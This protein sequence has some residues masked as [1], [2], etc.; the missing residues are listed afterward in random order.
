MIEVA[1]GEKSGAATIFVPNN[2]IPVIFNLYPLEGLEEVFFSHVGF[3]VL[4]VDIHHIEAPVSLNHKYRI[5]FILK[6]RKRNL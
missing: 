3:D 4:V 5:G 2:Q 1:L 6:E